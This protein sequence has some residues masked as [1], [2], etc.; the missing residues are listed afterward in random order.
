MAWNKHIAHYSQPKLKLYGFFHGLNTCKLWLVG[1][2][3]L[4]VEVNVK[5]IRGMI[6]KLDIHPNAVMNWWIA[7]ILMFNFEL[8]HV[9]GS[10]HKG[11]DGLLRRRKSGDDSKNEDQGEEAAEE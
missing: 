3:K 11:P 2:K 7:A 1:A 10:R 5:Y 8:V 6:N 9:P 4:K